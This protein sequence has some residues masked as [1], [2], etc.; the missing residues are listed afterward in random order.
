MSGARQVNVKSQSELD[1]GR[2]ETFIDL[3]YLNFSSGKF[4]VITS[5]Y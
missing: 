2:R 5:F 3:F 1:I 4:S